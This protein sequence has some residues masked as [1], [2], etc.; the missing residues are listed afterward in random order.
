MMFETVRYFAGKAAP[1]SAF[2]TGANNAEETSIGLSVATW[3]ASTNPY[4]TAALSC[5]KPFQTVISDTSPSYD[6]DKVP[7]NAFG[8]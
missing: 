3:N 6:S 2:H 4:N 1:T 5:A 7:G 8:G